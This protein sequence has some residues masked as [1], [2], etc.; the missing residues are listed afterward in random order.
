MGKIFVYPGSFDPITLGHT[1]IALRGL[2]LCDKLIVALL[3]NENKK[4]LFTTEERLELMRETFKGYENIEI[5][6]F[7]G[8]LGEFVRQRGAVAVLRGVRSFVDYESESQYAAYNKL[9]SNGTDTVFLPA[10]QSTAFISSS[11]TKEAA[12]LL[13]KGGD[14]SV[15]DRVVSPLVKAALKRKYS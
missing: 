15:L 1:D 12:I 14:V 13:Y 2:K 9:I 8:L 5:A 10:S 6:A 7:E 4:G 11:L 3:R